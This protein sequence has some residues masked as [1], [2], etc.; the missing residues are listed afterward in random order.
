VELHLNADLLL[1]RSYG[2]RRDRA[3]GFCPLPK[4]PEGHN[5]ILELKNLFHHVVTEPPV[6]LELRFVKPLIGS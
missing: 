1:I 2:G 4:I 5:P 3:V 6:C